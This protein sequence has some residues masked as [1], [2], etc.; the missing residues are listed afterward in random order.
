MNGPYAEEYWKAAEVEISALESKQF[1][2]VIKQADKMSDLP[3]ALEFKLKQFSNGAVKK[4]KGCFYACGDMQIQGIEFF[5]AYSPFVQWTTI[6]LMLILQCV[7]GLFTKQGNVTC[8]FLHTILPESEF[9]YIEMPQR[10]K[11]YN[12]IGCPKVLKL[13]RAL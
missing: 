2:A 7:L 13:K 3:S 4:F 11:Q 10:F 1:W 5:K 8:A 6:Q 12:K 9:V